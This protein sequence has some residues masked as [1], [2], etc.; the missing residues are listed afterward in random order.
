MI[1][2]KPGEVW[3]DTVNQDLLLVREVDPP[4]TKNQLRYARCFA[5]CASE[6]FANHPG[7][8][9]MGTQEMQFKHFEQHGDD[10]KPCDGCHGTGLIPIDKDETGPIMDQC[11]I[12]GGK[13]DVAL[14]R[15]VRLPWYKSAYYK[16]KMKK[17]VKQGGM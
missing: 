7:L 13:G 5:F 2:P 10:T 4:V 17:W 15:F 12:C 11:R 16:M 3:R 8:Q 6:T 14:T 9:F 1:E